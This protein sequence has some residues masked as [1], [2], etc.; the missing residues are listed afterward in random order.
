MLFWC[1]TAPVHWQTSTLLIR[2]SL[3]ETANRLR[4]FHLLGL[5]WN[6]MPSEWNISL[7]INEHRL[8]IKTHICQVLRAW[9]WR[10]STTN[11]GCHSG[12]H[13]S[14]PRTSYRNWLA[15]GDNRAAESDAH[16][17][18]QTCNVSCFVCLQ[19][20]KFTR[21]LDSLSWWLFW[22]IVIYVL[23]CTYR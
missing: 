12:R 17:E 15:V 10:E 21:R 7:A 22:S 5:P 8:S 1:T 16:A 3:Q 18:K 11:P 20:R 2:S 19:R 4:A 23:L 14:K 9:V 6:N 13:F